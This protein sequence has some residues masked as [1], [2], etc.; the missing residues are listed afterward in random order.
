MKKI[1]SIFMSL[2][3]LFGASSALASCGGS[4]KDDNTLVVWVSNP[5]KPDYESLLSMSGGNKNKMA[6]YT[7]AVVESFEAAHPGVTVRLESRGWSDSLNSQVMS[8]AR[9]NTLPDLMMGEM[10]LPVYIKEG[11]LKPISIGEYEEKL[12][13]GVIADVK[14]GGK[15]YGAPFSTGVFALQY[16]PEILE[17]A[18]IPEEDWE[19]ETWAEL[20]VNSQ[21]VAEANTNKGNIVTGGFLINNVAGISGAFR[22]LPFVRQAGGDFVNEN[23]E[24]VFGSEN[25][26]EAYKFLSD[27]AKTA[28]TG[29]L[30]I[31]AEDQLHNLFISG[32]AAYQLEG[33]WTLEEA[34]D[35]FKACAIPKPTAESTT[36]ENAYVGNLIMAM[37]KNCDNEQLANEFIQH[38]L[39]P[40]MQWELFMGDSRLPTNMTFLQEKYE[41]MIEEKP[42]FK[43]Y[44]DIM[45]NDEFEGGLPTFQRNSA[46]IWETWGTFYNDV[47]TTTN[48][49][50]VTTLAQNF[51][52]TVKGL[53]EG[54]HE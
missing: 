50:S 12:S 11:I 19:P 17:M 52:N 20:L 38:L 16:N 8:A 25:A 29:S 1:G 18:G 48:S 34:D 21:K 35:Y 30:D 7:K 28:P 40:N 24:I 14:M 13:N 27:L 6:L 54:L 41:E 15:L 9:S 45:L 23:G 53:L 22:A 51:E 31:T 43:A 10:Y 33:P 2:L 49:A 42:Y 4:K 36:S 39:S 32:G 37:T 5:L 26:V 44:L 47:L 46:R 3:V